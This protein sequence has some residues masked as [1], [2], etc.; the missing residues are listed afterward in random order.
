MVEINNADR[1]VFDRGALVDVAE[2]FLKK[3]KLTKSSVSLAFVKA[4][5]MK[6]LNRT[7]RGYNKTTDVLSFSGDDDFLGEIIFDYEQ[8]KKQ[9]KEIGH[10]AKKE[11]LFIAIHGLLHL[12]GRNDETEKDRLAMVAEGEKILEDFDKKNVKNKKIIKKF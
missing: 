3:F 4:S 6:K 10:S 12:I 9:A 11:L 5:E 7:Y 2:Y 8:I 1:A